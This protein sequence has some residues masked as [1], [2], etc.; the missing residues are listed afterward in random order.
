MICRNCPLPTRAGSL[1]T[2]AVWNNWTTSSC[3][4][5]E[6][7]AITNRNRNLKHPQENIGM[8]P[9]SGAASCCSAVT[10]QSNHGWTVTFA[11]TGINLALGVFYAW[12]VISQNV[13][14]AWGWSETD[15]SLPYSVALL[16]FAFANVPGGRLQDKFGP[17]LVA[18]VGGRPAAVGLIFA[19][20]TTSAIGY[21]LCFGILAGTGIGLSY[22]STTA[23]A[24]KW[25][26][27]TKTGLVSGIVVSGFGLA[28]VYIAPTAQWLSRTV[29]LQKM[30][31]IFGAGFFVVV[32]GLAQLLRT[33]PP[34][35]EPPVEKGMLPQPEK[36]LAPTALA[37]EYT[38]GE[39]LQTPQFYL[40]WIMLAFASGAGLM[41]I[42]KLAKIASDAGI[43]LGF[44]LVAVLA[45]GNGG[46]RVIAGIAS[47]KIGRIRT[48]PLSLAY[49]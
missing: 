43:G 12:S 31:L 32:G 34:G 4:R 42:S 30:M 7:A 21:T 46:G 37:R 20:L 33:P 2:S 11:G 41:V 8:Q 26:N 22:A 35:Y 10:R 47:D 17:R 23:P 19:G 16:V 15:K 29:G 39:M 28:S 9:Q 3:E 27:K 6:D 44:V 5:I 49:K 38:P 24:L 45:V 40:L 48:M 36:R 25:F 13:P 14:E 1:R 18:S